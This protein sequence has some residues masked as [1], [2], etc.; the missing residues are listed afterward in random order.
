MDVKL[1]KKQKKAVE[2]IKK[3]E[4]HFGVRWFIKAELEGITQHS[5]DALV[6]K[7]VLEWQDF[8]GIQYYR[9]KG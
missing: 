9:F 4:E 5:M 1:S 8:N 6:N 3:M 7:N 2:L